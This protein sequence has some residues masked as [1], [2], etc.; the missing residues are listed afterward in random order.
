MAQGFS[1]KTDDKET[2][3][4]WG[5]C[6]QAPSYV[7]YLLDLNK[8]HDGGFYRVIP[9]TDEEVEIEKLGDDHP[10]AINIESELDYHSK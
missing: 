5:T 8:D 4:G 6:R 3:Y 10:D 1:F 9:M 7:C 2:I